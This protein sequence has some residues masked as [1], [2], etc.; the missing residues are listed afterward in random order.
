[1]L[2]FHAET[3]MNPLD[4]DLY[5]KQNPYSTIV[6]G[7]AVVQFSMLNVTPLYGNIMPRCSLDREI[8][9]IG[10]EQTICRFLWISFSIIFTGIIIYGCLNSLI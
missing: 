9:K 3:N 10:A 5:Q 1:M 4:V 6:N 2:K 8:S 7:N